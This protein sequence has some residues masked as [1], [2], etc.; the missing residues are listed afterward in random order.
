MINQFNKITQSIFEAFKGPRTKDFEFEKMNQEY[1][2]CKERMLSLKNTI[3]SYPERLE[4]YKLTLDSLISSFDTIFNKEQPNYFQF[5]TNVARAHKALNDKL[6]NMF[7]KLGNLKS[8]MNKW[9]EHC[10]S[11][12]GKLSLREEKR[13]NFD[14]Y[15]EKMAELLEE[16]NKIIIKGKIPGEKDEEK[17]TRNLKKYQSSGTEYVDATNDAYKHIG[18]FLDSRYDNISISVVEFIEIEA[19]FYNEASYIFNFFKNMRNNLMGLKQNFK[20]IP[21]DYD[22][23]NFI[24][25]KELL[26]YKI[27]EAIVGDIPGNPNYIPKKSNELEK[28][29]TMSRTV[30]EKKYEKKE[31]FHHRGNNNFLDPYGTY[32]NNNNFGNN[33]YN[34]NNNYN[35]NFGNNN[36]NYAKSQI[37]KFDNSIPDPFANQSN[38]GNFNPYG[39]NTI[40]NNDKSNN[41]NPYNQGNNLGDNP[42]D[43]P[44][45]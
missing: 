12:D 11:V 18:Y 39:S 34:Y 6:L 32:N 30:I 44:N 27:E 22:A 8:S 28:A 13:K 23:S 3:D 14:H 15:D 29:P 33:N 17:F 41:V 21:R 9:T 5:M 1:Q 26:K 35:N 24:R 45:I 16:R 2:M 31:D 42:F 7:T 40:N 10:S 25:G 20:P 19:A 37:N 4:G 38:N 43:H 36:N